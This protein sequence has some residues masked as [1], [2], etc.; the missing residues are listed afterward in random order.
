MHGKCTRS[1]QFSQDRDVRIASAQESIASTLELLDITTNTDNSF[2]EEIKNKEFRNIRLHGEEDVY[3]HARILLHSNLHDQ[4]KDR[5]LEETEGVLNATKVVSFTFRPDKNEFT[6]FGNS[7]IET[8]ISHF[9]TPLRNA[10]VAIEEIRNEWLLLK[11]KIYRKN[12]KLECLK[13]MSWN[14]INIM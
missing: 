8:L 12:F 1:Y 5:L 2:I 14:K 11:C 7:A 9:S 10:A 6:N 3:I 13:N 4:L